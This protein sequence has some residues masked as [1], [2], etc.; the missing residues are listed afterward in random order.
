VR[1]AFH[2]RVYA[3]FFS[4]NT[5]DFVALGQGRVLKKSQKNRSCR[6]RPRQF[7]PL[8]HENGS[9]QEIEMN[10]A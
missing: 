7:H 10:A 1:N 2:G 5:I 4:F 9:S 6:R 8:N 3:E